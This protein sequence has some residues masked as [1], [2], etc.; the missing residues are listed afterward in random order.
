MT[1]P[2]L[3]LPLQVKFT[4]NRLGTQNLVHNGF[5]FQGKNRRGDRVYWKCSTI[6]SQC[7]NRR[8]DR[9]YWKCSTSNCPATINTHNNVKIMF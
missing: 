1:N 7:K 5:T 4:T 3:Q 9:L 2:Q 6:T 8:G